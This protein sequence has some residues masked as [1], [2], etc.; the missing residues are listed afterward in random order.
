MQLQ[1]N[2]PWEAC[3]GQILLNTGHEHYKRKPQTLI[4]LI[5]EVENFYILFSKTI[6]RITALFPQL[7][8]LFRLTK[9]SMLINWTFPYSRNTLY[10]SPKRGIFSENA[11]LS[12]WAS[13]LRLSFS[14]IRSRFLSSLYKLLQTPQKNRNKVYQ[15][16]SFAAY[17]CLW[18]RQGQLRKLW[19]QRDNLKKAQGTSLEVQWLRLQVP[20]AGGL[21]RFLVREPDPS[22]RNKEPACQINK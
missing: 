16:P 2:S 10:G 7:R 5:N 13:W 14:L 4:I 12:W 15:Y 22:C 1:L 9:S 8:P 6:S 11:S 20:N 3:H 18:G 21:V 19:Q 17:A